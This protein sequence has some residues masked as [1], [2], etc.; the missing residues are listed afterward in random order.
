MSTAHDGG[1]AATEGG[2]PAP[3]GSAYTIAARIARIDARILDAIASARTPLLDA[4]LPPLTRAAD[5]SRLWMAAAALMSAAGDPATARAARRGLAAT[6]TASLLANQ[7]AKRLIPRRRPAP[8]LMP[9]ARRAHRRPRSTSFPSGHSASAAAFAAAACREKPLLAP[10]LLPLAAAVA[11]SRVHTGVHHPSDVLA[12]V[13]LGASVAG[14]LS[15]RRPLAERIPPRLVS[16]NRESGSP[17]PDGDG[18]VIVVNPS[19][20]TSPGSFDYQE[21]ARRLPRARIVE[22]CDGDDLRGVLRDA[23]ADCRVLGMCGG[24]GSVNAAAAVAMEYR[25]PLLALP[26]GTFNHFTADLDLISVDDAVEAIAA[27]TVVR[28][29]VG[30]VNGEVFLNTASVGAYPEFVRRREQLEE[31][32][33]KPVSAAIAGLWVWRHTEPLRARVEGRHKAIA[34]IFIGNGAYRPHGAAP[35]WRHRL[36]SGVLDVRYIEADRWSD[37]LL[38]AASALAGRL[39]RSH[40]YV[41]QHARAFEITVPAGR[42]ILARDGEIGDAD[43]RLRFEVRPG[44]L[45]VYAPPRTL[46][47]P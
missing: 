8:G 25:V 6:A 9:L 29:D 17:L 40:R 44:A 21:L 5:H 18:V 43:P 31:H 12:G 28:V 36:D 22:L 42:R 27:G 26:G 23:A 32:L 10:V 7:V 1:T 13:A 11:Y 39:D 37:A 15:L 14:A 45:A 19:S 35:A 3:T 38:L 46:D 33:G 34:M 4:V 16:R 2:V 20:G 30:V 41:E 24:D 47:T